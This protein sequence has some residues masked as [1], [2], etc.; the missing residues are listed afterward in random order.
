VS[1]FWIVTKASAKRFDGPD[2]AM[3]ERLALEKS[4]GQEYRILRCKGRLSKSAWKVPLLIEILRE[5]APERL[6]RVEAMRD[7]ADVQLNERLEAMRHG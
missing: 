5:V 3:T 7:A 4:T 6:A 1:D 2:A